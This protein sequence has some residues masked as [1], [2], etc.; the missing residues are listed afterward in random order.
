MSRADPLTPARV[1]TLALV[2][3]GVILL[4]AP[5]WFTFVFATQARADIFASPPPVWFGTQFVSH[6]QL[7]L[8]RLP[9]WRYIGM[10]LYVATMTTALNRLLCVRVCDATAVHEFA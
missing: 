3:A 6:V 10:S 1:A 7:L 5:F 9:F 4:A 8:E 2:G